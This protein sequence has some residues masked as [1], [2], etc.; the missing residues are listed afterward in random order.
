MNIIVQKTVNEE[1]A[2]GLKLYWS[3]EE[4]LHQDILSL[5]YYISDVLAW[6]KA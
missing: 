5:I 6:Y 2:K 4:E 1:Q 3:F